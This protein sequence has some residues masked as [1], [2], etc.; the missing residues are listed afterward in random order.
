MKK[1][2]TQTAIIFSVSLLFFLVCLFYL[3]GLSISNPQIFLLPF[4]LLIILFITRNASIHRRERPGKDDYKLLFIFIPALFVYFQSTG[5]AFTNWDD[6]AYVL[7]NQL[8]RTL[9]LS[10]LFTS[11][12][13]GLYQPIILLSFWFDYH[14]AGLNPAYF[15]FINVCLHLVN[16]FLVYLLVVKIFGKHTIA[17]FVSLLFA[18]HPMHIESVAWIT[19]RKDLL[20]SLFFLL[21][22]NAYI[23]WLRKDANGRAWMWS[24]LFFILALMSKA[25]AIALFP[26]LFLV[27]WFLK[28]KW[29]DKKS[30][31]VKI[32]FALISIG[33]IFLTF[34]FAEFDQVDIGIFDRLILSFYGLGLYLLKSVFPYPVSA[35]Y[36]YPETLTA[37][38][39]AIA[40]VTALALFVFFLKT[41]S[42]KIFRFGIFF[43]LMNI[44]FMLQWLPNTYSLMADRYSYVSYIGLFIALIG[45]LNELNI[46]KK[47]VQIVQLWIPALFC[48]L[49][50]LY[51]V[52]QV[53]IWSDSLH[54]WN[55]VLSIYPDQEDALNN[56]GFVYFQKGNYQ[57]ALKDF[58][59]ALKKNPDAVQS[60]INRGAVFLEQ[61]NPKQALKDLNRA[62]QLNA[63]NT[64]ALLNR[65]LAFSKNGQDR[66]AMID[67]N[68][69]LEKSPDNLKAR[70]SR[71]AIYLNNKDF[72]LAIIDLQKATQ[73]NPEDF[74][75][76]ANLGLAHVRS[77]NKSEAISDFSKA[78][79]LN[80]QF[81]DAWSNRGL[82]RFQNNDV[83]GAISDLSYAIQLNPGMAIAYLN[84]GRAFIAIGQYENACNDFE[85]AKQLGLQFAQSEIDKYCLN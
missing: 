1:H 41:K 45:I 63:G 26:V 13:K 59:R 21:S 43:F 22:V 48:S 49:L 80:K 34:Y 8:L 57:A 72:D 5:F 36:P 82:A 61:G 7:D 77:G 40:I 18:V 14:M 42:Y 15:H 73:I 84:R 51:S 30:I 67:F 64:E 81:P 85:R 25:Q 60:L 20:Y 27:D 44:F 11:S 52:F 79:E 83:Q 17:I 69:V 28:G 38:H 32:P 71:G 24:L 46:K 37:I 31:Y 65:G 54:L 70:V 10:E 53:R 33:A 47:Q 58:D 74:L 39:F 35:I 66:E 76:W 3:P 9:S 75:A 62:L 4:I 68:A 12:F 2:L 56:R 23:S 16:S 29:V 19:E 78:I 55:N 6:P 50:T